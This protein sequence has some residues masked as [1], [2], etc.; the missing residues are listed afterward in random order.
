L[1]WQHSSCSTDILC[2]CEICEYVGDMQEIAVVYFR[3][4]TENED[5]FSQLFIYL[6]ERQRCAVLGSIGASI[7]DMYIWP[8]PDNSSLPSVLLPFDGPG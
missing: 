3:A 7:K 6:Q 2:V 4:S 5:G 1:Q 8:L